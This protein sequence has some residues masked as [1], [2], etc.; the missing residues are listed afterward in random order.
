[1]SKL[2]IHGGPKAKP[3]LYHQSNRY[4]KEE[5]ALLKEVIESGRLMGPGGKILEFED[6]VSEAFGVKHVVMVTSGTAALHTALASC[7]GLPREM[8]SSPRP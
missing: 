2:A 5:L 6:A 4:G 8:R 3:T 1:M 7:W